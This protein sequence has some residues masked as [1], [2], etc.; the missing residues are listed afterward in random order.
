MIL[1]GIHPWRVLHA[2][3]PHSMM[4]DSVQ[5][6]PQH[7]E[8]KFKKD[9]AFWLVFITICVSL[10]LSALEFTG[11][12]TALPTI[13]HDLKGDDFVW[14]GSGYALASTA[15]LPLSGGLAQV[16]GRR[17]VM[18]IALLTFSLGSA[19]CGSARSMTWLIAARVVQGLGGG[20]LLALPNIILSD[21]VPLVERG[22]YH[23]IIG[24]T[25]ALAS[26]IAPL[27]GGALANNGQWR[28]FFYLNLPVCGVAL[29]LAILF[30]RL[31]TP[32]GTLKEKMGRMD[33][34]G[35]LLCIG[36]TTS[37]IVGLTWGGVTY[38]WSSARVSVAL[39]VG[40][41]GFAA[42]IAYE[43]KLAKNPIIPWTLLQNRTSVSGYIQTFI[44]PIGVVAIIYYLPSY[45]Q[46][47]KGDSPISSSVNSLTVSL[48]MAPTVAIAGLSITY[49]QRYRP[50]AWIAWALYVVGMGSYTILKAETPTSVVIGLC[51]PFSIAA[52]IL[53]SATY[54]P[55]L[56]PLP[57]SENAHALAFFGFC[58]SFAAVWGVSIGAAIL[59]N[60][61]AK[62]LP[63]DFVDLIGQ[64]ATGGGHST[65]KVNLAYSVIPIIHTLEEPLKEQVR[66][67]FADSV[68][69]IWKTMTGIVAIGL[70]ASLLMGDIPMHTYVDERWSLQH[71]K[72]TDQDVEGSAESEDTGAK[73]SEQ[74][75]SDVLPG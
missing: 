59:Q 37:F 73:K 21:L 71:P 19:F 14:V 42:F 43:A 70:L 3:F 52:G 9:T 17:A 11:L 22:K 32:P 67:A 13:V 44:N 75:L 40:V 4:S 50:Q 2:R 47:C 57:V 6:L 55:V 15:T 18:I 34:I 36:S 35:N 41:A 30:L 10:F 68:A 56:S 49:Y 12:S 53:Y 38:P 61:L 48:G 45:Y 8:P 1:F 64:S 23:G 51:V 5:V 69:V 25:W 16:F 29:A 54:F 62:R 7:P 72:V 24:L 39:A 33:W 65:G 74:G 58:R 63:N 26:A 28:W 27:I 66:V 31:P 46:A 20:G 60:E